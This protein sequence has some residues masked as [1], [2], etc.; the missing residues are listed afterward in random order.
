[1]GSEFCP[2]V[3][4]VNTVVCR[5]WWTDVT[6]TGKQG[7]GTHGGRGFIAFIQRK[8]ELIPTVFNTG[9]LVAVD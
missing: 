1:M 2:H 4:K 5:L 9:N 6:I 8:V 3:V 7:A